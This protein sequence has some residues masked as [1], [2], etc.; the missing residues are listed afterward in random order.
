MIFAACARVKGCLGA[1]SDEF[2][3][4]IKKQDPDTDFASLPE[5]ADYLPWS[6][7]NKKYKEATLERERI[8]VSVIENF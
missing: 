3:P 8:L 5:L 4:F 2:I 1:N 6:E 7:K